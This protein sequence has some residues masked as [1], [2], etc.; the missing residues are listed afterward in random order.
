MCQ[1]MPSDREFNPP[2]LF[3]SIQTLN[4]LDEAH[5]HWRRHCFTELTDSNAKLFQKHRH[6]H[7]QIMFNQISGHS[8]A[9]SS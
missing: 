1:I 2:L 8:V 7:I 9:E 3:Y 6:R 5:P 4:G